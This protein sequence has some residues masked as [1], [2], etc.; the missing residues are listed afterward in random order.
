MKLTKNGFPRS[1]EVNRLTSA[2]NGGQNLNIF[3]DRQIINFSQ[4]LAEVLDKS[5]SNGLSS[6]KFGSV[7]ISETN[8]HSNK[9]HDIVLTNPIHLQPCRI[10]LA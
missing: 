10:A 7:A 1:Q 9:K 5:A 2:G 8:Y 6:V 3:N 4:S